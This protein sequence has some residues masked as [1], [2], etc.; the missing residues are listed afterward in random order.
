[1]IPTQNIR[2]VPLWI[3]LAL[4]IVGVSFSCG[5]RETP[6]DAETRIRI[7][8]IVNAQIARLQVM[9]DSLCSAA[10]TNLLPKLVDS[11]A[12][13][14]REQVQRQLKSIPR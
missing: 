13:I 4:T 6:L 12:H 10:Q 8:S 7:D 1:M 11:I 3:A 14:R 5:V 9:H 2:S